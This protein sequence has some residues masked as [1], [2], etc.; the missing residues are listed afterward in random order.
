MIPDATPWVAALDLVARW[1]NGAATSRSG[2][3]SAAVRG[4]NQSGLRYDVNT[5][6][7]A[8]TWGSQLQSPSVDLSAFLDGFANGRIV[9]CLDCAGL[10]SKL[11]AQAGADSNVVII[12]WGFR[13]YWLR[14]IGYSSY[15]N[16]LFG[17]S[18]AFSYHAFASGDGASTV[19]D[20]CLSVDD[21]SRPWSAPHREG[22]PLGMDYDHYRDQ[23]SP[24]NVPR[25][26]SGPGDRG[27]LRNP[28]RKLALLIALLALAGPVQAQSLDRPGA[29]E[30]AAEAYA[31]HRWPAAGPAKIGIDPAAIQA[32]GFERLDM[33]VDPRRGAGIVRLVTPK[34]KKRLPAAIVEVQVHGTA[35]AARDDLL[36]RL[37]TVQARL[38][39]EEGLGEVAF[40]MRSGTRLEFVTG[41]VGNVT[42]VARA[43]S[44]VDVAPLAAAVTRLVNAAPAREGRTVAPRVLA[45]EVEPAT[46]GQPAKVVLDLDP[47]SPPAAYTAISCSNGASVLETKAGYELYAS[48]PGT[49]TITVHTASKFLGVGTFQTEVEVAPRD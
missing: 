24:D 27:P 41:A 2:V 40:G 38:T 5:G 46:V 45:C 48:K 9:N 36:S 11:A 49:V 31:A 39:Q 10:V 34:S 12:G 43:Q 21:D 20:A 7:P 44:Q 22:L 33:R 18:H 32:P 13:L 8:Y 42:Y 28:M 37:M 35:A 30:R 19:H 1:S 15:T 25:P 6:A 14:G 3:L 16:S 17:G 23:L 29:R 47:A 26:G 4:V